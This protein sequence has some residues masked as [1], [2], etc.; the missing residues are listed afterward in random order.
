[1]ASIPYIAPTE[2]ETPFE[3]YHAVFS[4]IMATEHIYAECAEICG[5]H[6]VMSKKWKQILK[7]NPDE[8]IIFND[9]GKET[10]YRFYFGKGNRRIYD[11]YE[12]FQIPHTHGNCFAFA[13]FLSSKMTQTPENHCQMFP[14]APIEMCNYLHET[15]NIHIDIELQTLYQMY[16]YND[17]A[18]I[19]DMIGF[20]NQSPKIANALQEEWQSVPA[21]DEDRKEYNIPINLTFPMFWHQFQTLSTPQNTAIWTWAVFDD[22]FQSERNNIKLHREFVPVD[23]RN[24]IVPEHYRIGAKCDGKLACDRAI[25]G[26]KKKQNK[27]RRKRK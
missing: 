10:H 9:A 20:I 26:G 13:L 7:A 6:Y 23:F 8:N 4:W 15:K 27:T 25:N 16:V 14:M 5:S 11:P 1:M 12:Y 3:S 22:W 21:D 18:I 2:G 19:F 24:Y 17:Y